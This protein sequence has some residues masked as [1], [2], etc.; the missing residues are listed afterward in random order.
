MS[1]EEQNMSSSEGRDASN[2]Q[3]IKIDEMLTEDEATDANFLHDEKLE[4][5]EFEEETLIEDAEM[6]QAQFQVRNKDNAVAAIG[7]HAQVTIYNYI[8]IIHESKKEA[9]EDERGISREENAQGKYE[10]IEHALKLERQNG[11]FPTGAL[12]DSRESDTSLYTD[13]N[14]IMKWYY[15]LDMYEQCY[16]QAVAILHGAS[17]REISRRADDLFMQI[18]KQER[19]ATE[20]IPQGTQSQKVSISSSP[21]RNRSSKELHVKTHIVTRRIENVERLFWSDIDSHGTSTFEFRLLD[22]LAGEFMNKGLHGQNLLETVRQWSQESE[23]EYSWLSA[24]AL[25]IFLWRQDVEGLRRRANEWART[26]SLRSW[27]RTAM[28]LDGAYEI[29]SLKYPK[30]ANSGTETN[31]AFQLLHEWEKQGQHTPRP[32]DI[33]AKCAAANTYG[34]IGK[35]NP[36]DAL[37]GLKELLPLTRSESLP[38]TNKLF[39]TVIS[40]YVSLSWTGYIYEV[41]EH[42]AQIAA[43]AVLQ[44]AGPYK[45]IER[46]TYRLRCEVQLETALKAFFLIA[47]DSLSAEATDNVMAYRKP[48]PESPL[49]PDPLGRDI[50]LAGLLQGTRRWREQIITL[51]SAAIIERNGRD[52]RAAFDLIK[53]WA[54]IL[55]K[56]Q[57]MSHSEE[58]WFLTTMTQCM[59]A[60]GE[61]LHS[62]CQ[63]LKKRKKYAPPADTFYKKQLEQWSRGRYPITSLAQDVLAQL[64]RLASKKE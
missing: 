50:V 9:S 43:E 17:A 41:L 14:E 34:L 31:F 6:L 18:D 28:L 25:G 4:E 32:A 35:R 29:D 8:R 7:D 64:N 16:V 20:E 52:R 59:I 40:A 42:L 63:D 57:A 37:D 19:P 47:A 3:A 22:F 60:L 30:K 58:T 13:E 46:S 48:L 62:W 23:K 56:A 44:Q 53:S 33:Y 12:P 26:N 24:R 36:M 27:R 10:L 15:G 49:F 2:S 21:L 51:L 11:M 1:G 45:L 61:M 5:E 39:A 54:E 55:F 38:E